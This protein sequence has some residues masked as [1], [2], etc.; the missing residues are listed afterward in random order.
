MKVRGL[1]ATHRAIEGMTET[2]D[3]ILAGGTVVTMDGDDRVLED[4]G[5]AIADGVIVAVERTAAL[6]QRYRSDTTIPVAGHVVMPGLVDAYGHAGHGLIRGL[7]HPEHGWP[8]HRLYWHATTPQ[9][10]GAEARLAALER[11]RFG[12]TT[13][14]SVIGA[15][16]PRIDSTVFCDRVA[17]GHAEV[18]IR[19][20]LGVGPPDPITSHLD[21]PWTGHFLEDGRWVARTFDH[22]DALANS[23]E[24][25]ER[26]H[27]TAEGRIRIALAPPYLFGRH[28]A[29]RRLALR[30]PTADDAG[31]IRLH[32]DEM[33]DLADRHGVII[34]THMFRDS[35]SFALQHFGRRA[36]ER[37]LGSD[38]VI[39]HANGLA[40]D[41]VELVG[42]AGC[43]IASVA[44]TH[45]NLW[46]GLAPLS[47]LR[48]AGARIA[49]TTDGAAPY[50]SLDLWRELPRTI[51][52]HW[53]TDG[54]QRVLPPGEVLRMVTIEAA[55]VLGWD[56]QI[57]SLEVGKR[58]DV[59][60]IDMRRPHLTPGTRLPPGGLPH[61]LTH[62]VTGRDVANVVVD[63]RL[64][65]QDGRISGVDEEAVLA[66]AAEEAARAFARVDIAPYLQPPGDRSRA[67]GR[68][69]R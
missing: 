4:A 60:T 50:A 42:A 9:W 28:V 67:T 2:T 68:A 62:Y 34:H 10:W 38:V 30:L 32:A 33:R 49:I 29:H 48:S 59:I 40:E 45:E 51:W 46:Y 11:L 19:A 63:G 58:A 52:N 64:L 39:A 43:G 3:L 31:R 35:I 41:E 13:G 1:G 7:F 37:V 6:M 21:E 57:G 15:T 27:G 14:M 20:V 56:D 24:A 53:R 36:I 23:V 61:L 47:A 18:G 17:E 54:D 8:A 55:E 69:Q 12:V 25:I 5:L 16:P 66:E 22:R 26:W 65:M 44:Q